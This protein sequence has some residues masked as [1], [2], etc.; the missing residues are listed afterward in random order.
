MLTPND[1][2]DLR[3]AMQCSLLEQSKVLTESSSVNTIKEYVLE[4]A[5]YEQMLNLVFNPYSSQDVYLE[6]DL[7]EDIAKDVIYEMTGMYNGLVE[8]YDLDTTQGKYG[9][10]ESILAE[11]WKAKVKA[12]NDPA[13][14][15][16]GKAKAKAAR[17]QKV[18]DTKKAAEAAKKL[19]A[20][21]A[22]KAAEKAK[23]PGL[24]S[25]VKGALDKAGERGNSKL[26]A[27]LGATKGWAK[28]NKGKA[29]LAGTAAA[30]ATA[31]GAYYIYR[32]MRK[33]GKDKRAAAQA[34]AA[35][36]KTPEEKAKWK[37]KASA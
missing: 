7:L 33:A 31:A 28:Q 34:A 11:D 19:A 6:S 36:A 25:R 14:Q 30:A 23:N 20:D 15:E 18:A 22:K 17:L 2:E 24:M 27:G 32:K 37:A 8:D 13:R 1:R 21:K 5:T 4:E 16:L 12:M 3:W 29:A 26:K 10:M 35:A 9:L